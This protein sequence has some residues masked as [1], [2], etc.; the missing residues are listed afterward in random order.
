[1]AEVLKEKVVT[2]KHCG[3]IFI[4]K[5][6]RKGSNSICPKCRKLNDKCK[7][8]R[9]AQL[10]SPVL[11]ECANPKCDDGRGLGLPFLFWATNARQKYCSEK[12]YKQVE[13]KK[14]NARTKKWREE[15]PERVKELQKRYYEKYK[16][17]KQGV[18]WDKNEID[19]IS[20]KDG[21][22]EE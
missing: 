17:K 16:R 22:D 4:H 10:K 1:M 11:K 2:C 13:S 6:Y 19:R 18:T 20:K 12:C 14:S 5:V 21:E 3:H 8:S 7:I 9:P 15:N